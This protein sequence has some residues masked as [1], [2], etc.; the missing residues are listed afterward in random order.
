MNALP[1]SVDGET[2]WTSQ[3][4]IPVR[5]LWLLLVYA[6][7][8]AQF[9]ERFDGL[10]EES[11]DLPELLARLLCLVVERRL[12]QNLTRAYVP[13]AATL[14]RVR[15]RIDW[16]KTDTGMLLQRGQV[17]CQ[18]ED[19]TYDTPRNRLVRAALL[20]MSARM[21]ASKPARECRILARQLEELGVSET[22]PSRSE[23][24]RERISRHDAED[25][26]MITIAELALDLILP[27]EMAG[28]T[29]ATR[30]D[31]DE[32]LLRRIFEKAVAGICVHEMHGREG[33]KVFPQKGLLWDVLEPTDG[34]ANWLPTMSA[35]V[36][37]E[38]SRPDEVPQRVIIETKFAN[39]LTLNAYQAE[40]FK[41]GHL[42]QLY[43]YL[44]TQAD[45]GGAALSASEGVLVYPVLDKQI[46]EWAVIQGHRVRIATID[47]R[48]HA[49]AI[50][51]R[52]LDLA[53]GSIGGS[54]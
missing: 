20:S 25:R 52:V 30:L 22:R 43:A 3:V 7:D 34:F 35:D 44:R 11:A 18:F 27:G 15:G 42:Y 33:W 45:K 13:R 39:A 48:G 17:A 16:L 31:R 2:A 36:V 28:S 38:R 12:H 14:N 46:D 1:H 26:L 37:L 29:S 50:K 10:A 40:R 24:A 9:R 19:L 4:G 6:A 41:S 21:G 8:L 54:A 5:N 53:Q 32:I 47:L 23:M 49:D 51:S